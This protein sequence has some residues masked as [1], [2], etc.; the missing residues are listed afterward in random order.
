MKTGHLACCFTTN[1]GTPINRWKKYCIGSGSKVCSSQTCEM[2]CLRRDPDH[3]DTISGFCN[4]HWLMYCDEKAWDPD[5]SRCVNEHCDLDGIDLKRRHDI[6]PSNIKQITGFPHANKH[7]SKERI[8]QINMIA[9]RI[10]NASNPL[11]AKR[12]CEGED[13]RIRRHKGSVIM[14]D[15]SEQSDIGS[16]EDDSFVE[17]DDYS[18][19]SSSNDERSVNIITDLTE[20][21]GLKRLKRKSDIV[22]QKP[23]KKA[24]Y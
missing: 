9:K 19:S 7:C 1:V 18:S 10:R 4:Q 6:I 17:R 5:L 15:I 23:H 24:R 14:I 3:D 2:G 16:Y 21:S 11:R 22:D 8:R 12:Q 13:D 20:Q